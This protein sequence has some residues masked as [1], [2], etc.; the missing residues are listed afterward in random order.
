MLP[1]S[2]YIN[3]VIGSIVVGIGAAVIGYDKNEPEY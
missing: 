3:V 2:S 1:Q